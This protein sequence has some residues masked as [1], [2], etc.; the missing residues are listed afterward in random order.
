MG[1]AVEELD[2]AKPRGGKPHMLLDLL[3]LESSS[4]V[5]PL[6]PAPPS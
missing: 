4:G 1:E 6:P 3:R 2:P 5:F